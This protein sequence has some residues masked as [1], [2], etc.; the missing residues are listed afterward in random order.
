VDLQ[1][2]AWEPS[3]ESEC[4]SL[5][6]PDDIDLPR[7]NKRITI[8]DD[9]AAAMRGDVGVGEE[10]GDSP[11][12]LSTTSNFD[13]NNN[14]NNS[15][16]GAL[17]SS[18]SDVG[19]REGRDQSRGPTPS[20]RPSSRHA[21]PQPAARPSSRD[22]TRAMNANSSSLNPNNNSNL[23]MMGG[24][25]TVNIQQM[26]GSVGG[27]QMNLAG[28]NNNPLLMQS[29]RPMSGGN[30]GPLTSGGVQQNSAAFE[31]DLQKLKKLR[32][33][34][35]LHSLEEEE[36]GRNATDRQACVTDDIFEAR[37][38]QFF[39]FVFVLGFFFCFVCFSTSLFTL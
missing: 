18:S 7:L 24:Q 36:R 25:P 35:E 20:A 12:Q 30:F 33:L 34:S 39:V 8:S 29:T 2:G 3:T 21:S 1:T 9:L 11:S 4:Y 13:P 6:L 19:E 31:D 28:M 22:H 38:W 37:V 15:N 32:E 14:Y 16:R 5:G 27:V 17:N 23:M 10:L 26:Q